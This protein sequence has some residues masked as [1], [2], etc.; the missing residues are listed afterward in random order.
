MGADQLQDPLT[1]V[2]GGIDDGARQFLISFPGAKCRPIGHELYRVTLPR[3]TEWKEV[4]FDPRNGSTILYRFT[5][6][7]VLLHQ[8]EDMEPQSLWSASAEMWNAR[9]EEEFDLACEQQLQTLGWKSEVLA[10]ATPVVAHIMPSHR[11]WLWHFLTK[12]LTSLKR[13]LRKR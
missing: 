8:P 11:F 5:N 3:A 1:I 6:G 2:V 4:A 7:V 9:T 12:V 13:L 10:A